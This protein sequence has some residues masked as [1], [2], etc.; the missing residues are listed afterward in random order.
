M[1]GLGGGNKASETVSPLGRNLEVS[2][3]VKEVGLS[4]R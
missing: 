1:Q 4:C 2:A 3:F